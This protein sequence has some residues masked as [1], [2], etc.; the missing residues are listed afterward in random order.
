MF[1]F[2]KPNVCVNYLRV[3]TIEGDICFEVLLSSNR[4]R[5]LPI[6]CIGVAWKNL[7]KK[8]QDD[9]D[10]QLIEFSENKITLS[11]FEKYTHVEKLNYQELLKHSVSPVNDFLQVLVRIG[12]KSRFSRISGNKLSY[13]VEA[14]QDGI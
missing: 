9:T 7:N 13:E 11:S 2:L 14:K 10:F 1:N 4:S 3:Y 12:G 8:T 5:V 6:D